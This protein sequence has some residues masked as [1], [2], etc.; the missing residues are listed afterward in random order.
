DS[1]TPDAISILSRSRRE[2]PRRIAA[3][4]IASSRPVQLFGLRSF[5]SSSLLLVR[6]LS[7]PLGRVES[8]VESLVGGLGQFDQCVEV[9]VGFGEFCG[10][11]GPAI[12]FLGMA[13]L[14][15]GIRHAQGARDADIVVL[16]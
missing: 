15:P 14:Y 4:T 3:S 2:A 6:R 11:D 5:M 16:A 10:F 7:C 12:A 13:A 8:A 1:A 9:V